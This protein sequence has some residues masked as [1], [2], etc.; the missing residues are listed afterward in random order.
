MKKTWGTINT[1]MGKKRRDTVD[2]VIVRHLGNKIP[3][4]EIVNA[5]SDS[6]INDVDKIRHKCNIKTLDVGNG[7]FN[8][9]QAEQSMRMPLINKKEVEEIITNLDVNKQP[10]KDGIRVKDLKNVCRGI[11]QLIADL[12]NES[13]KSGRVPEELKI[14]IVKPI[15][16]KGDHLLYSNY[17]QIH[18]LSII[19]KIFEIAVAKHFKNYI[20]EFK[21]IN[22]M[23]FGFQKGKSTSDL[24]VSFSE[25]I[26]ANLNDNLHTIALFADFTKAF[27]TINHNILL[28][29]LQNIGI[30]GPLL[31]WFKNYLSERKLIVRV[32]E[33]DSLPKDVNMG[34]PQ[35]SNLGPLLYI[36]YVNFMFN[37]FENCKV[38]MF[39]DDTV[40]L[41]SHKDLDKAVSQMQK[42]FN[43]MH[44]WTHDNELII[45]PDKTKIVHI[46]SPFNKDKH[47]PIDIIFHEN[48]CLHSQRS[49]TCTNCKTKIKVVDNHEYLGISIDKHFTWRSHVNTI[50]KRLRTCAYNFYT[51]SQILP[52]KVT[53]IVYTALVESIISYG[54][55]AWGNASIVH[56]QKIFMLQKKIIKNIVPCHLK[57]KLQFDTNLFFK[58]LQILNIFDIY[59][60]KIIIKYYYSTDHKFLYEHDK[61]TR[62][63]AAELYRVPLY[64]N[65]YGKRL[66]KNIVPTEFNKIPVHLKKL[67]KY[68]EIKCKIKNWLLADI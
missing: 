51:L 9:V 65:K 34:V 35:G 63:R 16:K 23:Q 20:D 39:A 12:I 24:L 57:H 61:A 55:L 1:I 13:I 14:S 22:V 29:V 4:I 17:R 18:L 66:L 10:G 68:S 59:R 11:S 2:E 52:M 58:E 41:T 43:Q 37:I 6:F 27:D 64:K 48:S 31:N 49:Q 56:L 8:C 62:A 3:M 38:Y 50:C 53:K 45:N 21:I 5:F 60:Y 19:E 30:R 36:I 33:E 47:A 44:K 28:E 40:I 32:A 46:C 15:Y 42:K 7:T 67:R 25:H 54:I 26:N